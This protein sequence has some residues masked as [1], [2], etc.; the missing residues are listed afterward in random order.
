MEGADLLNVV[1]AEVVMAVMMIAGAVTM[2]A[3]E[4]AV[5]AVVLTIVAVTGAVLAVLGGADPGL[6][7]E[8]TTVTVITAEGA[9]ATKGEEIMIGTGLVEAIEAVSGLTIVATA[10]VDRRK[11]SCC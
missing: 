1:V 6:V 2:I 9:G 3:G 4:T 8:D 7:L 10:H 11:T 5:V